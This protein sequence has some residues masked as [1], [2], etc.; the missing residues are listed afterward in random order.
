MPLSHVFGQFMGMWVPPLLAAEVHFG[1]HIEPSRMTELIHRERISVLVAVPRVLHLL[2]S[3]L[4]ARYDSL[5][6]DL[7]RAKELSVWKR[8]WR[9]RQMHRA[10]RMEVL[11]GDLGWSDIAGRSRRFLEQAWFRADSG[12]WHDRDDRARDAQSS[13]SYWTRNN[14]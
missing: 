12:L 14:R 7:E 10:S 11:G 2:R 13:I 1:E 3:H 8:W 5:A 9:F 4:L 6:R